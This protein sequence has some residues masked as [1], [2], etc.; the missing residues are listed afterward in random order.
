[1]PTEGNHSASVDLVSP[2]TRCVCA[3][4]LILYYQFGTSIFSSDIYPQLSLDCRRLFQL[5]HR[6]RGVYELLHS[7]TYRDIHHFTGNVV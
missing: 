7:P 1:M 4:L 5:F 2:E 3:H 6:K